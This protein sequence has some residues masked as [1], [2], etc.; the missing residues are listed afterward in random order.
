MDDAELGGRFH[1]GR[2]GRSDIQFAQ[3]QNTGAQQVLGS[4]AA[5][6]AKGGRRRK[7]LALPSASG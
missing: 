3:A 7:D 4:A 1:R 2:F 5:T 6:A